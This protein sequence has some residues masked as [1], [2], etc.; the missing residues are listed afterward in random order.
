MVAYKSYLFFF[1]FFVFSNRKITVG[2]VIFKKNDA[3][4]H[5]SMVYV[6]VVA[7]TSWFKVRK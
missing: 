7:W 5:G 4:L 3:L 6:R 1:S 2:P